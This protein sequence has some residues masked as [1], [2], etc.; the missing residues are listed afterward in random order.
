MTMTTDLS[1]L[2]ALAREARERADKATPGP[3]MSPSHSKLRKLVE[4]VSFLKG[5]PVVKWPGFDDSDRSVAKHRANAA[6]IAS[7]RSD[8]PA[9]CDAVEMLVAALEAEKERS[10]EAQHKYAD[11]SKLAEQHHSSAQREWERAERAN[12]ARRR[13]EKIASRCEAATH[14]G[15][16]AV[17][18]NEVGDALRAALRGERR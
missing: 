3:W 18:L 17:A 5:C 6:F 13:V 4:V 2:L 16:P 11:A 1:T 12:M 8:V 9:L 14:N 15:V 10:E 7:A